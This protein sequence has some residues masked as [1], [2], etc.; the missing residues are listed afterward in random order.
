MLANA[1]YVAEKMQPVGWDIIV[2]DYCWSDPGTHDN[3]RNARANAPLAADK[4]DR[5]IPAPNR[6]P[7]PRMARVSS[8]SPIKS[9][10]SV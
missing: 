7:R 4:F 9:T 2:V 6:F 10:R 5:M 1:R 8:R 3:N